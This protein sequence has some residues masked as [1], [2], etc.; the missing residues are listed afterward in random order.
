MLLALALACGDST[1]DGGLSTVSSVTDASQYGPVVTQLRSRSMMGS[2]ER[3]YKSILEAM[4][5][6]VFVGPEGNRGSASEAVLIGSVVDV[7]PGASF[8]W[9]EVGTTRT[10][11]PF[12]DEQAM[13]S[14]IHVEMK[15]D[16]QIAVSPGVVLGPTVSFGLALGPF[17]DVEAAV[18]EL[19]GLGTILVFLHEHSPVFDYDKSLLSVLEDG[20]FLGLVAEDGTV[21]FPAM[22]PVAVP[23]LVPAGLTVDTLRDAPT[24]PIEIQING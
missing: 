11:L 12:N 19:K 21:T 18:A 23:V 1:I 5:N 14:T 4:P 2:R 8:V 6:V 17:V 24:N 13:S 9:D 20:A 7:T 10:E 15:I 16:Q 22:D 3:T